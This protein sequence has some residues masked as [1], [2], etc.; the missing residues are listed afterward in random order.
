MLTPALRGRIEYHIHRICLIILLIINL[1]YIPQSNANEAKED[2]EA[3]SYLGHLP[4][5]IVTSSLLFL[6]QIKKENLQ[7]SQATWTDQNGVDLWFRERL[8]LK[9]ERARRRASLI[10]DIIV[11][12]MLL[13]LSLIEGI[14]IKKSRLSLFSLETVVVATLIN[15]GV[16][17]TTARQRPFCHFRTNDTL[18]SVCKVSFYSGHTQTAFLSALIIADITKR[19]YSKLSSISLFVGLGLATTVGYLRI[20]ADK[21]YMTDVIVGASCGVLFS[22]LFDRFINEEDRVDITLIPKAD[23]FGVAYLFK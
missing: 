9:S 5:L 1:A 13:P 22:M 23:G 16:K 21:H 4:T 10:S 11:N 14:L 20:A 6:S 17:Y 18:S 12:G 8:V 2:E 15:Q 19:Y 3:Y 7:P